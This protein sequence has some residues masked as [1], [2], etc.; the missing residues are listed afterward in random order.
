MKHLFII[1]PSAGKY[2][3]TGELTPMIDRYCQ[4]HCLNYEIVVSE[5]P[6]MLAQTVRKAAQSGENTRAYICGGDGSLNEAANEVIHAK[7]V[8]LSILPCGTGNDFV[9]SF[10]DPEKFLDLDALVNGE[11]AYLDL[12]CCQGQYYAINICSMGLDAR[13]GTQAG[14]YKRLPFVSGHGA[15]VLS[16]II[17]VIKGVSRHVVVEIDGKL[18]DGQQTMLCIANGRWYGGGF[19]AVPDAELD[20]GM[21]DVLL[22]KKVSRLGVARLV[23]RYQQGQYR[24]MPEVITHFRCKRLAVMCDKP[25]SINL[26]GEL[27]MGK[28]V[29]FEVVPKAVRF[30]YPRGLDFHAK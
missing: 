21:L 5:Q 3:H 27:R 10:H 26:D 7:N 22:V 18:I 20:D 29:T 17:N 28:N 30:L 12:I 23:R 13:I 1:N 19:H 8:V 2:D 16:T 14:R 11:E 4:S 15:Y 25:S 6:G 24:Q 9:R